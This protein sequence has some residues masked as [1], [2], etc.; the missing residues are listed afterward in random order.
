MNWLDIT[1]LCLT[2][3]GL[4]KGLFDGI[5]K[6]AISLIAVIAAIFLYAKAGLWLHEYIVKLGWFSENVIMLICYIAGF[7][8]ILAIVLLAGEIIHRIIS[9]TPLSLLNH[10]G[11]GVFGAALSL[12]FI[13]L[14]LN[15]IQIADTQS[16]VIPKKIKTTSLLYEPIK[17]IIPT[18]SPTGLF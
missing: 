2:G 16:I 12:I 10:L 7:I 5:I 18:I 17:K 13:S 6:Q 3:V 14:A 8:F 4:V 15:I 1:L 9:A 11:G